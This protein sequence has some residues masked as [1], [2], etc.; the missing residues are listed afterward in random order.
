ME[1]VVER[2]EKSF[3]G[4]E[5]VKD[6][7]L[8]IESGEFLALL[9]PSG[10]GKTTTLLTI[11]GIYKPSAGR[12][13]FGGRDVTRLPPKDRK[14][15]M[16][17]QSYA[18]YPHMSAFETIAFPLKL[19]KVPM[20]ERRERA[21]RLAEMMGIAELLGRKPGQLSGG[22]QQR[23]ALARALV[24]E[25]DALLFDEPLSNLDA[26]IRLTMRAEITRLQKQLGI[27]SIYVTHDQVEA[28]SMADRIGVMN[29]GRLEEL[30]TP[31]DIYNRPA[32]RFV[33]SFVGNPPMN[34][35]PAEVA[36]G[37]L[38][39]PGTGIGI[40]IAG[41][42]LPTALG[43]SRRVDLGIRPEDIYLANGNGD[44]IAGEVIIVEPLGR[45]DVAVVEADGIQL[46]TIMPASAR[47][48][49]G[50][51]IRIRIDHEKVQ[52]FDP[53]SGKSLLW[54]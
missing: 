4:V 30:G 12:I 23:V 32:T 53:D 10:C 7:D 13:L 35:V 1:I 28:I 31:D 2:L 8:E 27:T 29:E 17:F 44:G 18:L 50:D 45:E 34:F 42:R 41:E 51:R 11:A 21:E 54:A 38:L 22:Q 15:G 40:P 20:R 26:R 5:A 52:A 37:F 19:Q 14:L 25:P 47:V 48:Q 3:D 43:R 49:M 33:A 39:V 6:V 9:G 16:V 36:D 46:R 24:K